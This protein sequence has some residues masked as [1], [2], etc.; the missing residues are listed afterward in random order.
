MLRSHL[1]LPTRVQKTLTAK[2]MTGLLE[3]PVDPEDAVDPLRR[4][5]ASA[6]REPVRIYVQTRNVAADIT[7]GTLAAL[8]GVLFLNQFTPGSISAG[9]AIAHL[10]RDRRVDQSTDR[11]GLSSERHLLR[12]SLRLNGLD[13]RCALVLI[14]KAG[15][16]DRRD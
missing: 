2:L 3:V 11:K 5:V 13:Q 8:T 15:A 16:V 1:G 12:A 9:S 7:A 4:I 6:A 10:R 14:A